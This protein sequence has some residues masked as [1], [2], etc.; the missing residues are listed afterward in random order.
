MW[1]IPDLRVMPIVLIPVPAPSATQIQAITVTASSAATRIRR[2][3]RSSRSRAVVSGA[4]KFLLVLV[5]GMN[6][7]VLVPSNICQRA[8]T[9]VQVEFDRPQTL[10]KARCILSLVEHPAFGQ[11]QNH[12]FFQI[13]HRVAYRLA[14]R[15]HHIGNLDRRPPLIEVPVE[16]DFCE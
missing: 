3:R 11:Y 2:S 7:T 6:Q 13:G 14:V 16:L 1:G 15:P 12:P 10:G 4:S 9:P 8:V 5:I